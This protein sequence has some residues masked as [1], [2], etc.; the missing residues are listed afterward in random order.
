[1]DKRPL[2]DN[3]PDYETARRF[4]RILEGTKYS[5]YV[6]MMNDIWA[7]IGSPKNQVNWKDPDSWIMQRLTGVSRELASRLWSESEHRVNPRHSYDMRSLCGHHELASYSED[8]IRLTDKGKRFIND[9]EAVIRAV[10]EQEGIKFVLS[11]IIERGLCKRRDLIESFI[12]YCHS[13]TTWE[14]HSSIDSALSARFRHLRQRNFI[15]KI[16]HAYQVTDAGLAYVR[17]AHVGTHS[18]QTD[19]T[20]AQQVSHANDYAREQLACFLGEMDPFQ[21]EH[22]VK[23]LLEELGYEDV[24]V[25]SK[26]GD[27]GVD[28]TAE[29]E[30]GITRV[31]EVIQV[32]RQK[33]NIGRPI[34]NEL[35]GSL[36]FF[37]AV[38]GSIITTGG[39]S[40]QA[41]DA[42]FYPGAAPITLID[43]ERLLDLLIK[44]DIGVR[45]REISIIEFDR[46]SLSQ[47]DSDDWDETL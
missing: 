21:L 4:L 9:D 17:G 6:R 31:R 29:I 16:G 38:R 10:D 19:F 44:H 3:L 18:I 45:S 40:K 23:R 33:S 1:M 37:R 43:G 15:E 24:E 32:K 39:F 11:E 28:V 25:T 20:I 5:H 47:F 41:K 12:R 14:A 42:A 22:L 2:T 27:K 26:T 34:L 30:L 7:H 46:D 35:R 36:P 13:H 8:I